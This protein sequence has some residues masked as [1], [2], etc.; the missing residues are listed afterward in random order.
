MTERLYDQDSH[1]TTF[2]AKVVS[3]VW[4]EKK[5]CYGVVLGTLLAGA[6]EG[7]LRAYLGDISTPM[8]NSGFM[9]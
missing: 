7:E 9:I 5:E 2:T 3:C 4:D 6:S 1:R 8:Q